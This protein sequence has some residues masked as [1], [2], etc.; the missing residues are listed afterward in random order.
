MNLIDPEISGFYTHSA[1]D[2]RLKTGLGPLEFERNKELI[3]RYL[4]DYACVIADVGGGT[5]HYSSW[6]AGLGHRVILIDPVPKL[7]Q[8]AQKRSAKGGKFYRTVLGE[9]RALPLDYH[10]V[11]IVIL[12]GPLYHLQEHEDRQA[13]LREARRV[14]KIGGMVLGFAINYTASTLASLQNG[15]FHLPEV[16]SMCRE[17]LLS[18]V[19]FPPQ[20]L[21]GLLARGF[22]HKPSL[23]LQEFSE[24]GFTPVD[25]LAV[26]G[27]AWLDHRYFEHWNTDGKKERLLE[28]I[29]LTEKDPEL[30]ALSP[31][32]ML[33][34]SIDLSVE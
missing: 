15:M 14:L 16:C 33:A 2:S 19:H 8:L 13:A 23:L 6:L 3:S 1:E 20:E 12:H 21:P 27:M 4:P 32:M 30:L 25:L 29:R 5:G 11:D 7:I 17:E 24:A 18:G 28:L 34:A 9:A 31:H 22:F 26:E 10:S